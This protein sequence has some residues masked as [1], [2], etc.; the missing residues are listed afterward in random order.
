MPVVSQSA[1]ATIRGTLRVSVRVTVDESGAVVE[2]TR[3]RSGSECLLRTALAG[4]REEMEIPARA[5]GTAADDADTIRLHALGGHC[6]REAAALGPLLPRIS[7]GTPPTARRGVPNLLPDTSCVGNSKGADHVQAQ[8]VAV[9]RGPRTVPGPSSPSLAIRCPAGSGSS[10]NPFA[11]AI[12]ISRRR[13]VWR[14]FIC[15]SGKPRAASA[16]RTASPRAAC[17][18]A[19]PVATL[20]SI[21]RWS[22]RPPSCRPTTPSGSRMARI[23]TRSRP[24]PAPS[25]WPPRFRGA[26]PVQQVGTMMV[27]AL[28]IARRPRPP[29]GTVGSETWPADLAGVADLH[30][31]LR[32]GESRGVVRAPR[33]FD[34]SAATVIERAMSGLP[35]ASWPTAAGG[36][37]R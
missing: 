4:S 6:C 27:A 10:A 34:A 7:P 2:A 23:D 19:S 33:S 24:R 29:R 14:R 3:G 35:S 37:R 12:S 13:Q 36:R 16:R 8:E 21:G 1:L 25:V 11:S 18:H 30:W 28:L 31:R 20:R 17:G 9:R 15:G 32:W 26:D 22:M 5:V